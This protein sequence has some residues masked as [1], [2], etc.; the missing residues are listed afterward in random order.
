[1]KKIITSLAA[2]TMFAAPAQ[3][4]TLSELVPN[5]YVL[6]EHNHLNPEIWEYT[7][8][9][10]TVVHYSD[11]K[12]CE[13]EKRCVELDIVLE[14]P[15]GKTYNPS[16]VDDKT[17]VFEPNFI[18]YTS[19]IKILCNEKSSTFRIMYPHIVRTWN[20]DSYGR[21][22]TYR[23]DQ[24]SHYSVSTYKFQKEMCKYSFSKERRQAI[25][26]LDNLACALDPK[27]CKK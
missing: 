9:L 27:R 25:D 16:G 15:D 10:R 11:P 13:D 1:M 5:T 20:Q 21:R 23:V 8:P 2:L 26:I 22:S 3:A 14:G 24:Y 4:I 12:K 7:R 18:Q 6:Q 17:V 19:T